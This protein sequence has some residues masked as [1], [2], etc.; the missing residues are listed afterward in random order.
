MNKHEDILG[1]SMLAPKLVFDFLLLFFFLPS[2]WTPAA[3]A[4]LGT[5]NQAV[6][7]YSC[8][9]FPSFVWGRG[10]LTLVHSSLQWYWIEKR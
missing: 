6:S 8:L 1:E 2:L 7:K 5:D 10:E 3:T 9:Y 4:S